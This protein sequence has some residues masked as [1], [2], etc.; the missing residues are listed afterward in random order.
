MAS[1]MHVSDTIVAVL[2]RNGSVYFIALLTFNILS[3][4][5]NLDVLVRTVRSVRAQVTIDIMSAF[6]IPVTSMVVSHFLLN[7]RE[8]A[9]RTPVRILDSRQQSFNF[10]LNSVPA[11][12]RQSL[13]F[14]SV[15]S[16]MGEDLMFGSAEVDDD[17]NTSNRRGSTAPQP[18]TGST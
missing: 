12:P 15:I 13:R 16:N 18:T 6:Q 1:N 11:I 10:S 17:A 3:F 2:L 8:A 5:N 14:A 7:L 9:Y 4:L